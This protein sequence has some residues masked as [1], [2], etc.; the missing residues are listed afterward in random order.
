MQRLD[1]RQQQ[2]RLVRDV[3]RCALAARA[4]LAVVA[5]AGARPVVGEAAR[6]EVVDE[7]GVPAAAAATV[8]GDR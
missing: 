1:R 7:D 3:A 8:R 5:A 6:L 2:A 4:R